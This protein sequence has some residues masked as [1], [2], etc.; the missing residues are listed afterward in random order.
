MPDISMCSN[1]DCPSRGQCY[2]ARAKPTPGRQSYIHFT[3]SAGDRCNYFWEIEGHEPLQPDD[4]FEEDG[5]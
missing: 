3:V 5:I 1:K 4:L 2:R